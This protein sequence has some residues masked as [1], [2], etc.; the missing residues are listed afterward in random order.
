MLLLIRGVDPSDPEVLERSIRGRDNLV[1]TNRCHT[2][3]KNTMILPT[4]RPAG[5]V[6]PPWKQAVQGTSS[7]QGSPAQPP[8]G[9]GELREFPRNHSGSFWQA[10][11]LGSSFFAPSQAKSREAGGSRSGSSSLV[12]SFFVGTAVGSG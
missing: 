2:P 5:L 4:L 7:L 12:S 9:V 11:S 3:F 6:E 8:R 1:Q 10:S